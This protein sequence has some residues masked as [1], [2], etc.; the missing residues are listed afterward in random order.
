MHLAARRSQ[1]RLFLAGCLAVALIA[2]AAPALAPAS[3]TI[4]NPEGTAS[5]PWQVFLEADNG[6][7]TYDM[8][9]GTVRDATHV[10]TAAHCLYDESGARYAPH[11]LTVEAGVVDLAH[12]ESTTQARGV[13]AARAFPGY[14]AAAAWGDAAVLTLDQPLDLSDPSVVDALPLVDVGDTTTTQAVISGWGTSTEGGNSPDQLAYAFVDVYDSSACSNYGAAF[15]PQVMLC[16]GRDLGSGRIVDS[17][18]GDSGGP[19]ARSDDAGNAD[20]LIG[21][22]S[23]GNGCAKPGFPGIYTNVADPAIHAFLSA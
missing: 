8:C 6:D 7:G 16:A 20:A 22:V 10:V 12:P 15:D 3:S 21:I 9:G 1:L 17:C 23:W 13:S 4:V 11:Q 18:Q 14:D 2:L 5:V 19:L